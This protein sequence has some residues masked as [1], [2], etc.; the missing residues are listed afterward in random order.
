MGHDYLPYQ[1]RENDVVTL[2]QPVLY[3]TATKLAEMP[4]SWSLEDYRHSSTCGRPIRSRR[5]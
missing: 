5:D 2:E 3:G 1:A 4:I